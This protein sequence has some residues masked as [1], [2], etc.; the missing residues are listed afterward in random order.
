MIRT[1][2]CLFLMIAATAVGAE[3]SV[4]LPLRKVVMFNSGLGYF[5]HEKQINGDV[6]IELKFSNADI[7]DLLKSLV[8]Q[9]MGGGHIT[10]VSLPSCTPLSEQLR[11]FSIDLTTHPTLAELLHQLRGEEIQLDG[12]TAGTIIGVELKPHQTGAQVVN[13]EVL[14]VLTEQGLRGVPL[15]SVSDIALVNEKLNAE[16]REALK[17]L[18]ANRRADKKTVRLKFT[19]DGERTVRIG[20]IRETPIWKTSY[21]VVLDHD[22]PALIQGWAILENT[23]DADW[24]QVRLTLTSGRPVT[25]QMDLYRSLFVERQ[26][27]PPSVPP[28]LLSRVYSPA[29]EQ[30]DMDQALPQTQMPFVTSVTPLIVPGYGMGGMGGFGGGGMGMGG[31]MGG[32][33]FGGGGGGGAGGAMGPGPGPTESED[34]FDASEGVVA[35]AN[36][37]DIGEQFQYEIAEPVTLAQRHSAMIPIVDQ[38]IEAEQLSIY[39]TGNDDQHPMLAFRLTNSTDLRLTGGPVTVFEGGAYAGDARI[40][41]IGPDDERLVSYAQ[42]I[43]LTLRYRLEDETRKLRRAWLDLG[44]VRLEFDL[45]REHRYRIQSKSDDARKLMLEQSRNNGDWDLKDNKQPAETTDAMYRFEVDVPAKKTIE[46]VVVEKSSD[47]Q[48]FDLKT[49]DVKTLEAISRRQDLPAAVSDTIQQVRRLRISIADLEA[50]LKLQQQLLTDI[51]GEQSRIRSNMSPLDRDSELYRRYVTKL[52]SQE[53]RFDGAL[54][55]IAQTR[56]KYSEIKRQL[57][58][59]FPSSE[60]DAEIPD[61]GNPFGADENPFSGHHPGKDPFGT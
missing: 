22:K 33:S 59:F 17:L 27:V 37:S 43:D 44:V 61:G 38:N 26:E 50:Q 14:N 34:P 47:K 57:A 16:L 35:Q 19:G 13:R 3:E 4:D 8:V 52:T 46:F 32:G 18:V 60:D 30:L 45:E 39:T 25:F 28:S 9:D 31:G 2:L 10:A 6:E 55:A 21:R 1:P 42:D 51:Q 20:Y 53:D 41:F 23:S 5:E 58:K 36:A 56:V 7:N 49:I 12:K 11:S 54:Q 24:D 48:Q 29:L 40:E 15:D